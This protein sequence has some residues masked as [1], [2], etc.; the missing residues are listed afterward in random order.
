MQ[1][2]NYLLACYR[3]IELNPVRA[4]MVKGPGQ[5][6]WSSYRRNALG[7]AD[8][9]ITSHRRY[10]ALGRSRLIRQSAYKALFKTRLEEGQLEEI[11]R[12]W[13][14]GTP[15]GERRFKEQIERALGQRVGYSKR[16]RPHKREPVRKGL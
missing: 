13:E 14:T 4:G 3:Y 9:L 5:Y 8:E 15:L 6:R 11:R 16:G 2:E 7:H 12:A 1:E 10:R